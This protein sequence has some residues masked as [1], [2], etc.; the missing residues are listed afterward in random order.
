ARVAEEHRCLLGGL[1]AEAD[2]RLDDKGY[3]RRLQAVGQRRPVRRRKHDAET[4]DRDIVPV[5]WIAAS[6]AS[7]LRQVCD[8]LVSVK[9][10]VEPL[11]RAA[12][13]RTA[14]DL[15]PEIPRFRKVAD[16]EGEVERAQV[17]HRRF[18][19]GSVCP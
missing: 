10:E 8:D 6:V 4:R 18:R 16:W 9:V 7:A 1:T 19:Y 15:T 12:P 14:H 11:V 13:F 3:A 5:H 2:M 17:G